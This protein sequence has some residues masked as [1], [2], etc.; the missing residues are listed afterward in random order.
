MAEEFNRR[1]VWYNAEESFANSLCLH[2]GPLT[3]QEGFLWLENSFPWED[4]DHVS[5]AL[6]KEDCAVPCS[7]PGEVT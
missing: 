5:A 1:G 2:I 7:E 4:P 3:Q 6:S